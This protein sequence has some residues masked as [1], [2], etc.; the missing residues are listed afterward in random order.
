M[1]K[2]MIEIEWDKPDDIFWLN[3][4]NVSLALHAYCENTR[5]EV[6]EVVISSN[7]R[8]NIVANALRRLDQIKRNIY[9]V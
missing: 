6:K 8:N 2:I 9:H 1:P 3:A 4:D 5:F 7:P